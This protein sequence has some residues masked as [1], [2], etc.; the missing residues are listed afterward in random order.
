[1]PHRTESIRTASQLLEEMPPR[2]PCKQSSGRCRTATP[3]NSFGCR[4]SGSYNEGNHHNTTVALA[5]LFNTGNT[6]I[7]HARRQLAA[8]EQQRTGAHYAFGGACGT[9]WFTA[10]APR[11]RNRRNASTCHGHQAGKMSGCARNATFNSGMAG[12]VT[13]GVA[14]CRPVM[15]AGSASPVRRQSCTW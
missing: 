14:A 1:M 2:P 3:V 13:G 12:G 6:S 9:S 10:T 8:S 15:A 7:T 5:H 11:I 4:Y